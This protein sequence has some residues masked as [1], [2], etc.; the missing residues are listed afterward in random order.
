M[1]KDFENPHVATSQ[2][3]SAWDEL[4]SFQPTEPTPEQSVTVTMGEHTSVTL[5]G[6]D[7]DELRYRAAE[8][9]EYYRAYFAAAA[10]VK[11][12]DPETYTKLD[13]RSIV[14]LFTRQLRPK[15]PGK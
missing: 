14:R 2:A 3:P 11:G 4:T 5:Q 13:D 15:K 10:Q 9:A 1:C 8:Q 12:Q 7:A 6:A